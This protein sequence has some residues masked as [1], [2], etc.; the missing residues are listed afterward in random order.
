MKYIHILIFISL[1]YTSIFAQ[2]GINTTDP[3]ST[4]DITGNPDVASETDGLLLPRLSRSQLINKTGYGADQTGAIVFVRDLSGVTNAQTENVTSL[5]FYYWTGTVWS[6]LLTD[7]TIETS[8]IQLVTISLTD[9]F[10][11]IA[12]GAPVG[13]SFLVKI[14]YDDSD[15]QTFNLNV[16]INSGINF[17]LNNGDPTT[18]S[19]FKILSGGN[20]NII[21]A[22]DAANGRMRMRTT[23]GTETVNVTFKRIF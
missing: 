22:K 15:V 6:A 4:L 10:Q 23:G 21:I 20:S 3:N 14:E 9:S 12:I 2:V 5:G 1:C 13:S 17:Y 11:Y 18:A 16:G 19:E 8:N 7:S